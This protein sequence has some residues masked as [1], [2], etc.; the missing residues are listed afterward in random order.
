MIKISTYNVDSRLLQ[1]RLLE[2]S[3]SRSFF[4]L[5]TSNRY[6]NSEKRFEIV[7]GWGAGAVYTDDELIPEDLFYGWKFGFLGYELRTKFESVTQENQRLG[8]W[9]EAQFF[10]PKVAGVLHVDGTLDVWADDDRKARA[11]LR[12][13]LQIPKKPFQKSPP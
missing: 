11:V 4:A 8:E 1:Y 9:P 13:L 12:E 10:A 3:S 5:Y 7:F 2:L 6:P